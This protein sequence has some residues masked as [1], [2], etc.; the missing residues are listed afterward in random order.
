MADGVKALNT[1]AIKPHYKRKFKPDAVRN[2]IDEELK[3]KLENEKYHVDKSA[4]HAKEITDAVKKRLKGLH[5]LSLRH[6]LSRI[7]FRRPRSLSPCCSWWL[8]RL[9][10][11]PAPPVLQV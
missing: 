6:C 11:L 8:P 9:F 5:P 3:A 4:K 1:Y 2:I 10:F 7:L